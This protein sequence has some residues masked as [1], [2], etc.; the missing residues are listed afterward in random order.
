MLSDLTNQL[1]RKKDKDDASSDSTLLVKVTLKEMSFLLGFSDCL[2]D[3]DNE[4]Q[5]TE[6]SPDEEVVQIQSSMLLMFQSIENSDCSGTRTF[7]FS[8]DNLA[9]SIIPHFGLV[10]ASRIRPIIGPIAVEFRSAFATENSGD[11]VSQEFSLDCDSVK[12]CMAPSDM[13]ILQNIVHKILLTL[14]GLK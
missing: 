14:S 2:R 6:I 5:N 3:E 12:S 9:T 7:H 13:A 4:Y 1:N 10:P 8:I 11:K